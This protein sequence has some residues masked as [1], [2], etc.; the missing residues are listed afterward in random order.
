MKIKILTTFVL[1]FIFT[2]CILNNFKSYTV[3]LPNG[4][5]MKSINIS[6]LEDIYAGISFNQIEGFVLT[7]SV[8]GTAQFVILTNEFYMDQISDVQ[9]EKEK[10]NKVIG[11]YSVIEN[12]NLS[13][14]EIVKCIAK[15]Y[16]AEHFKNE[17]NWYFKKDNVKIGMLCLVAYTDNKYM[18]VLS[19]E[20]KILNR[21]KIKQP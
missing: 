14:E 3:D 2:S 17:G 7:D 10:N 4:S 13:V 6:E 15:H 19:R 12:T 11:F 16:C 21:Y 9:I 5:T 18:F 20:E 8:C 1:T